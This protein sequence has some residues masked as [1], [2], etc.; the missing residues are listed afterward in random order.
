MPTFRHGQFMLFI[1]KKAGWSESLQ[2]AIFLIFQNSYQRI[3]KISEP[4]FTKVI[5]NHTKKI[6]GTIIE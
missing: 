3:R 5:T 4:S 2:P 6:R 1:N